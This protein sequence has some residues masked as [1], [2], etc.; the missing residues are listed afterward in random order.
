MAIRRSENAVG[1]VH[2]E[3][4]RVDEHAG[5]QAAAVARN[6]LLRRVGDPRSH[7]ASRNRCIA[8][9]R[10]Q[11]LRLGQE[12][13]L[14]VPDRRTYLRVGLPERLLRA[15]SLGVAGFTCDK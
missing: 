8:M 7:A 2:C 6:Q 10:G 11:F 5:M 3:A 14:D 1:E 12:I 15:S 9:H 13:A 4:V